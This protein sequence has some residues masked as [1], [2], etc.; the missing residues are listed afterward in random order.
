MSKNQLWFNPL[1]LKEPYFLD[2]E[3]Y[4]PIQS[5]LPHDI[6]MILFD[7]KIK[8]PIYQKSLLSTLIFA[9][10]ELEDNVYFK[11]KLPIYW[12]KMIEDK[13]NKTHIYELLDNIGICLKLNDI[14]EDHNIKTIIGFNVAFDYNSINRLYD[15]V[16]SNISL[17][18]K[19]YSL[20]GKNYKDIPHKVYNGFKKVNYFDIYPFITALLEENMDL[21]LEFYTFCVV[22][23]LYTDSLKCI[24]SG[25]EAF[26]RC[27]VDF[28]VIEQH[29]GLDDCYDE[30]ELWKWFVQ[31]I[32]KG[33]LK[34]KTT[35][36]TKISK[37]CYS[38]YG[39]YSCYRV[40]RELEKANVDIDLTELKSIVA[41]HY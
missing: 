11:N 9:N 36:N 13:K 34:R 22:N 32:K 16:N 3:T 12:D 29:M 23:S 28:D 24:A 26:H 18:R 2:I 1:K 20:L 10:T 7:K 21:R 30:S 41:T 40:L 35:L 6:G 19:Q 5:A 15:K 17:A 14:I 31:Q 27:F 4:N 8:K 37:S 25:E 33:K 39:I 38:K